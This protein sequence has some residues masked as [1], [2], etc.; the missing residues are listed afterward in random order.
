MASKKNSES[1]EEKQTCRQTDDVI[2]QQ[3]GYKLRVNA[4]TI[5]KSKFYLVAAGLQS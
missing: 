4:E 1:K 5:L 2:S 3:G